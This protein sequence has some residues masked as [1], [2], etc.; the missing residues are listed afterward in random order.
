MFILN[1]NQTIEF[2]LEKLEKLYINLPKENL[3][4][5]STAK[6]K[7]EENKT[8]K[9][10]EEKAASLNNFNSR[11]KGRGNSFSNRGRQNPQNNNRG[12]YNYH[13]PYIK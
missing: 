13:N 1:S 11:G 9:E 5:V 6:P 12:G 10:E 8:K 3:N 4:K 2:Q 7:S